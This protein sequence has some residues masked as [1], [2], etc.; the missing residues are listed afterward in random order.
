[1]PYDDLP[2]RSSPGLPTPPPPPASGPSALR[3]FV[4]GVVAVAAGAAL[5]FWW[6]TRAQ[7]GEPLPAPTTAS[8][9][10]L[11]G[12]RPQRQPM[13]LPA[14]DG[15]DSFFRD[16]IGALSRHPLLARAITPEGLIRRVVLA[17]EQIADGRT[18]SVPL[19]T[20]RPASRLAIVGGGESGAIDPRSYQRWDDAVSALTSINPREAAQVYV[21]LKP[22][23]D[24]A[25]AE[26]GH[27]GGDFDQAITAAIDTLLAAPVP[28]NAP[29]LLRR[30][31]YY[32]HSDATLRGL[33]PVQKQLVLL[34][35]TGHGRVTDWMRQLATALDLSVGR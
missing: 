29:V 28:A 19:T 8:D 23:F 14:L 16:L 27:P 35:P 10:A 12:N 5:A 34:G 31:G 30:P 26:L 3:W 18:P 17:V 2:L 11:A 1:M 7:P 9:G 32:E 25:Y 33:R 24:A 22:L 20:L 4:V 21:N 13:E 6:M 15:S